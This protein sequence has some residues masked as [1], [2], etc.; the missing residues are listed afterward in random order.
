MDKQHS[1]HTPR[2]QRYPVSLG[3]T[4]YGEYGITIIGQVENVSLTGLLLRSDEKNAPITKDAEVSLEVFVP[5]GNS[6]KSYKI[7]VRVA[8]FDQQEVGLQVDSHDDKAADAMRSILLY[9][10]KDH[11]PV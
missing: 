11:P 4:L 6:I 10:D 9:A 1:E 5:K 2:S 8:R 3:A 7:P